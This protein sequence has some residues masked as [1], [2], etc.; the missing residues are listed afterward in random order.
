[1]KRFLI[2]ILL[3]LMLIVPSIT[4][5]K[6]SDGN[7]LRWVEEQMET[8][9]IYPTPKIY[10]LP[11]HELKV[12]YCGLTPECTDLSTFPVE[13]M[14]FY[15]PKTETVFITDYEDECKEETVLAHE[16]THYV[17][18]K[19][20]GLVGGT[21]MGRA[22]MEMQAYAMMDLYASKFCGAGGR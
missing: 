10:R 19:I 21:E 15:N 17:Q 7:V 2:T 22:V 16:L 1:M 13:V 18:D 8:D 4:F 20:Y 14:A 12:L 5:A 11:A 3:G 6:T 9:Q